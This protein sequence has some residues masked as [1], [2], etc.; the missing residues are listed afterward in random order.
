MLVTI[1]KCIIKNI[2]Y[3]G[4][5]EENCEEEI[6]Y[7]TALAETHKYTREELSLIDKCKNSWKKI[8]PSG[9]FLLDENSVMDK[10]NYVNLISVMS[11]MQ[12]NAITHLRY[13]YEREDNL[14]YSYIVLKHFSYPVEIKKCPFLEKNMYYIIVE[15]LEKTNKELVKLIDK[16]YKIHFDSCAKLEIDPYTIF[17]EFYITPIIRKEKKIICEK[18]CIYFD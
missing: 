1:A 5:N 16:I 15:N 2:R 11:N 3:S 6:D 7:C 8:N 4:E 18:G 13:I 14:N 12:N 10:L 9:E 17:N